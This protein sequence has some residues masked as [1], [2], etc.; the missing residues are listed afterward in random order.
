M[1]LKVEVADV[2]RQFGLQARSQGVR[3]SESVS[4]PLEEFQVAVGPG[5]IEGGPHALSLGGWHHGI[6]GPLEQEHRTAHGP[7][8]VD[9]RTLLIQP[10]RLGQRPDQ[11]VGVVGLE[12]V[13]GRDESQQVRDAV[14]GDAGGE[15]LSSSQRIEGRHPSRTAAPHG[16]PLRVDLASVRQV[17]RRIEAVLRVGEAPL[18]P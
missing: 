4:L 16:H 5:G 13:G 17:P 14:P 6:L 10:T 1:I 7:G 15:A 12:I 3:P 2:E 18:T 11:T 9:G 8:A